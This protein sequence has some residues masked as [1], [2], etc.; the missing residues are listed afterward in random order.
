MLEAN[1]YELK[2]R[3]AADMLRLPLLEQRPIAN[4]SKARSLYRRVLLTSVF[5]T[6]NKARDPRQILQ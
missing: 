4:R 1:S 5:N 2:I 3:V 6:W